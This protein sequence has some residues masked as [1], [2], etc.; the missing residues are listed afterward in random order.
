M[1]PDTGI[2]ICAVSRSRCPRWGSPY[3]PRVWVASP[4]RCNHWFYPGLICGS[5]LWPT[6]GLGDVSARHFVRYR[7]VSGLEVRCSRHTVHVH[8]G[9]TP[10]WH[11][12]FARFTM[13]NRL[14]RF[15]AIRASCAQGMLGVPGRAAHPSC[16]HAVSLLAPIWLKLG[17]FSPQC[18]RRAVGQEA[19]G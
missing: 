15:R 9:P 18:M 2:I 10:R 17:W 7:Q 16:M 14:R 12:E 6:T 19:D 1:K 4:V 8:C 11:H 3:G 5:P 13:Q